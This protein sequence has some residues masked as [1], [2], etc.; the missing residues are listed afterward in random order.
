MRLPGSGTLAARH[1]RVRGA[2][3]RLGV[4]ALIVT[5]GPNIRYLTNH[6]GSAGTLVLTA[7][8]L[9][10]LVDSR[11]EQAVLERQA[12]SASCP[13]LHLW[14]VPGGYDDALLKLFAEI[15]PS[16]AAF[17][18]ANLT[19]ARHR[20]ICRALETAGAGIELRPTEGV[21]ESVRLVKDSAEIAILREAA[22]RLSGVA[23]SGMAAVRPGV[24]ERAVAGVIET[25]LR[26]AGYDRQ[27]FDTIVASG[28]NAALPHYRAGDR[29]LRE[30]DLVVL[31]FGGVLD[32]YCSDL[33]R[34]VAVGT[35]TADQIRVHRAVREAQRAAIDL[36][37]PGAASSDVDAA[38]RGVLEAY[39]LAEAFQH[40]TG[41]GLGLEVHE[42]PRIARPRHDEP[43]V[44]LRA[45]MVFT[46][47][48]GAYFPG[49]GGVRIEDDVLVTDEGR[50]VLTA[51]SRA[52]AGSLG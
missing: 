2:L 32:G 1:A 35:P 44:T 47:E 19:V 50:E 4:D 48:P 7:D 13:S 40:G 26:D 8:A 10:L 36:V 43:H 25:A 45:G 17:E 24:S 3:A 14:P 21:V 46:I 51:V 22:G 42:A 15:T 33:T 28:P 16:V 29:V 6:A 38:A 9:H 31:D 5:T 52:L 27:A 30:G 39:G 23:G 20:R 18:A 37:R 49:W 11:Y 34:T 12:S 41:H